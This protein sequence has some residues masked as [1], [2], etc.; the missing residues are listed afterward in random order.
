[1]TWLELAALLNSVSAATLGGLAIAYA[2]FVWTHGNGLRRFMRWLAPLWALVAFYHAIIWTWD[3]YNPTVNTLYW[4]R[5]CSWLLLAIPAFVL[6][7]SLLE[8]TKHREQ[9]RQAESQ[10]ADFVERVGRG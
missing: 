8:D 1:M 9:E 2:R 3:A 4:M 6:L 10:L 5:P 7:G